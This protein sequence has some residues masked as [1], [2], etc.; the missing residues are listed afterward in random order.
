MGIPFGQ[1]VI[2]QRPGTHCGFSSTNSCRR[3]PRSA[4]PQLQFTPPRF[5]RW[6]YPKIGGVK[7]PKM[8][9][10]NNEW[11]QPYEQMD[12]LGGF[13]HIFGNTH[14]EGV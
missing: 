9:G 6:I 2:S 10:E 14:S 11:I 7:T 12:D 3:R 4:P 8:D 1:Y 13:S 5:R